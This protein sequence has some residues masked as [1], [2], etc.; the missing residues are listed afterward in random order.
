[1][2]KVAKINTYHMKIF[3][4]FLE[5]LR[6][7]PDGD[8]SLLDHAILAYG[9]GMSDG[10]LHNHVNMPLLLIGGG[11]GRLRGGRHLRFPKGTPLANVHLT[12]LN[13]LGQGLDSFGDSA[14]MI[15]NLS[16]V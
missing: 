15:E 3:A 9:S 13:K 5:K 10:Q 14:G 2:E 12:L 11:S 6:S 16:D 7:T 4:H 1:M 8:G